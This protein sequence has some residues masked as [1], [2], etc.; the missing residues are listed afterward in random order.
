M[1]WPMTSLT[2]ATS[3]THLHRVVRWCGCWHRTYARETVCSLQ[4]THV[5][6]KHCACASIVTCGEGYMDTWGLS[7]FMPSSYADSTAFAARS[8]SALSDSTTMVDGGEG[9]PSIH[10]SSTLP[11]TKSSHHA[12]TSACVNPA[13]SIKEP[14]A[15][16]TCMDLWSAC[17]TAASSAISARSMAMLVCDEIIITFSVC[18]LHMTCYLR[19]YPSHLLRRKLLGYCCTCIHR[20]STRRATRRRDSPSCLHI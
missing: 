8:S 14:N 15:A 18:S 19:A 11:I 2:H 16:A 5:H 12:D 10:S 17:R 3:G 1:S 13:S 6:K 4:I 9:S 7:L 20:C